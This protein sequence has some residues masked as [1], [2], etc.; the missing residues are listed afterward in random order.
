MP[1]NASELLQ[2][3]QMVENGDIDEEVASRAAS[4]M[5]VEGR[6]ANDAVREALAGRGARRQPAQPTQRI[7]PPGGGFRWPDTPRPPS[8]VNTTAPV[9]RW[10]DV[11][12]SVGVRHQWPDEEVSGA[13]PQRTDAPART[14]TSLFKG[15]GVPLEIDQEGAVVKPPVVEPDKRVRQML[16]EGIFGK[17][18]AEALET[19]EGAEALLASVTDEQLMGV[20]LKFKGGDFR[21]AAE[22]VLR[23]W[24]SKHPGEPLPTEMLAKLSP[25]QRY[26][27][28]V[29]IPA[30]KKREGAS[31]IRP[32]VVTEGAPGAPASTPTTPT[33]PSE[34][35]QYNIEQ[36]ALN[37]A[38]TPSPTT[39]ETLSAWRGQV[40]KDWGDWATRFREMGGF[41]LAFGPNEAQSIQQRTVT[42]PPHLLKGEGGVWTRRDVDQA[43]GRPLALTP[44]DIADIAL[45][46]GVQASVETSKKLADRWLQ[47]STEWQLAE[48][49]A[50]QVRD[51]YRR[52]LE[53]GDY[54]SVAGLQVMQFK[55][56]QERVK[57]EELQFALNIGASVASNPAAARVFRQMGLL[58]KVQ[59]MT[60]VDMSRV[61]QPVEPGIVRN[62]I[63]SLGGDFFSR[64]S[65]GDQ[66]AKLQLAE[67]AMAFGVT[68]DDLVRMIQGGLPV[69][70]GVASPALLR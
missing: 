1:I 26:V 16:A 23:I 18:G 31:E 10:P 14:G 61:G 60:G 47:V 37:I 46:E 50:A 3:H 56:E 63:A 55:M 57:R 2:L 24:E 19:T 62:A 25:E 48:Q 53:Q 8:D 51:E 65:R 36:R 49:R 6:T 11:P 68:P 17:K 33:A 43:T 4:L 66:A 12:S 67:L 30:V 29:E 15:L 20:L 38:S 7:A 58:D 27:V 42:A 39:P 52:A 13:V 70:P 35:D 9:G 54:N 41:T 40:N 34:F 45:Y 22:E 28:Q 64:L 21:K 69:S 59:Q 44:S 32:N 5:E